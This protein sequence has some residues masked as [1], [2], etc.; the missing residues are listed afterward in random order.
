MDL[1]M[2]LALILVINI[3]FNTTCFCTVI[4]GLATNSQDYP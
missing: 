1:A 3:D 4:E 2:R